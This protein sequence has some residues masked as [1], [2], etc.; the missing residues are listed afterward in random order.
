[1]CTFACLVYFR[2]L[3]TNGFQLK[4]KNERFSATG[5]RCRQNLKCENFT[6]SFGRLR[7]KIVPKAL[8]YGVDVAVAVVKSSYYV[9]LTECGTCG[10]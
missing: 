1:M 4:A 3:G 2:L 8:I 7:S 6:S 10:T 5:S 9:S